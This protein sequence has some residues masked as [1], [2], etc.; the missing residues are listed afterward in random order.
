MNNV[1]FCTDMFIQ[2]KEFSHEVIIL[3]KIRYFKKSIVRCVFFTDCDTSEDFVK[4][5]IGGTCVQ[6]R[7]LDAMF[8]N[9]VDFLWVR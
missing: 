9:F 2:S 3:M 1:H 4:F 7:I 5:T 8:L 6:R